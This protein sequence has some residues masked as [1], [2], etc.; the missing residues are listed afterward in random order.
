MPTDLKNIPRSDTASLPK[1]GLPRRLF[2]ASLS[3]KSNP[4]KCP[5][6]SDRS[7]S[8]CSAVPARNFSRISAAESLS[9]MSKRNEK[10][11][12]TSEYGVFII[13]GVARPLKKRTPS[14]SRSSHLVNS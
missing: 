4:M 1:L 12:L 2:T 9:L 14:G 8:R 7:R 10:R 13:S 5:S 6:T 3:E 11:S